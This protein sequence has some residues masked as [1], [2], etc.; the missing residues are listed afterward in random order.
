M[1]LFIIGFNGKN[2]AAM[3]M[4]GQYGDD[5][6]HD[7]MMIMIMMITIVDFPFFF[8]FILHCTA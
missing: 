7:G 1:P 4:F 6:H 5:D 3:S 2:L 8:F